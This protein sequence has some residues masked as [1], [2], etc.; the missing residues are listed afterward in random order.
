MVLIST[1]STLVETL[2]D[3]VRINSINPAYGGGRGEAELQRYIAARFQA[4]GLET[5]EQHVFEG[6]SNVIAILPGRD[7][8]RRIVFEAHGDTV[9]VDGMTIPP[10]GA[11][12]RDGQMFGRGACDT[13]A[14]MA[15]MLLALIDLKQSGAVPQCDVWVAAVVDEEHTYR[16]V[17]RLCKNLRASAAV[18]AEP[19]RMRLVSA[20]KGCLR[21]RIRVVGRAAHSSKPFLGVNAIQGMMRVLRALEIDEDRLAAIQH[22]L[23]GKATWN[24]GKIE[25]GTQVNV[26]PADCFVEIDRRLIPGEDPGGVKSEYEQLINGLRNEM[27]A[28]DARLEEPF[29]TDW[30]LDTAPNSNIVTLLSEILRE[31]KL[32]GEPTGVAFGSDASKFARAGIPSV[33]LGPGSIDQAHTAD[34]YVDLDQVEMAFTVYRELMLRYC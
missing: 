19:T 1:S 7:R 23:V 9:G 17:V 3:L 14:G 5:I 26:V 31:Q 15:A 13:K 6:R 11:E 34:E 20:S 18:I 10:F 22:P 16:G 30:P 21:F 33:I 12:M 24:V 32:A 29:L 27:P 4:A 2:A 28:L 25:G 8:S